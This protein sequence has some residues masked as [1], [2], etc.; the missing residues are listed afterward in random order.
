[1]TQPTGSKPEDTRKEAKR[2]ADDGRRDGDCL[3]DSLRIPRRH[4]EGHAPA[5]AVSDQRS[6]DNAQL[7]HE[8]IH[9]VDKVAT[10]RSWIDARRTRQIPRSPRRRFGMSPRGNPLWNARAPRNLDTHGEE[11]PVVPFRGPHS[12]GSLDR[13]RS[14]AQQPQPATARLFAECIWDTTRSGDRQRARRTR[15][16]ASRLGA[17]PWR[18]RVL[19]LAWFTCLHPSHPGCCIAAPTTPP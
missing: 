3:G 5:H 6:T 11:R 1:M 9:E 16:T 13:W 15:Q 7:L 2:R 12:A 10:G 8:L 18:K 19:Q 14:R 4:Q 17:T